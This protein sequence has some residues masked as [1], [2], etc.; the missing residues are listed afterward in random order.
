MIKSLAVMLCIAVFQTG[1][2]A[3][4]DVFEP[5]GIETDNRHKLG[6]VDAAT[7]D[8]MAERQKIMDRTSAAMETSDFAALNRMAHEY[9]ST[10]AL[11]AS[12]T[13]KLGQV[14][15]RLD[16]ELTNRDDLS[17][18]KNPKSQNFLEQW[19]AFSPDE[20]AMHIMTSR[21]NRRIAWCFRGGAYANRVQEQDM[22]IFRKLIDQT[23]EQLDKVSASASKDPEFFIEMM[24]LYPN[25]GASRSEFMDLVNQAINAEPYYYAMYSVARHYFEEKWLG[26]PGDLQRYD[27]YVTAAT[28][29]GAGKGVYA[30]I[31]WVEMNEK[32]YDGDPAFHDAVDWPKWK[33]AMRDVAKQYPNDWNL[34]KFASFSCTAS[35]YEEA[36]YYFERM[37]TN[38]L[39][40]W[41]SEAAILGCK[42]S[43]SFKGEVELDRRTSW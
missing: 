16:Y 18:C 1:C 4:T 3:G 40:A 31:Q 37:K 26:E 2:S 10:R 24:H 5:G 19:A 29:A 39:A 32:F 21:L 17:A 34:S 36:Q 22:E 33:V 8:E 35:D 27:D 30:R 9:R 13:W 14:Y 38:I 6:K 41:S 43:T 20:P 23:Y 42:N 11:T 28:K 25:I 12:G 7:D 15:Q